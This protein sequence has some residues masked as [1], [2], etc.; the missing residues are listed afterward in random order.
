MRVDPNGLLNF[1]PVDIVARQAV[2]ISLSSSPASIFHLTNAT[3]PT[4][5]E[6]LLLLFE[7]LGI[8]E[9]QF[10]D[11]KDDFSWIDT[12]FDQAIDFYGSYLLGYKEFDRTNSDAA[13]ENTDDAVFPLGAAKLRAYFRWYLKHLIAKRSCLVPS[14]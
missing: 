4:V 14:R 9:P 3:P 2:K 13:V 1:I 12:K 6:F 11:N 8:K 7:E 5:A 10:V